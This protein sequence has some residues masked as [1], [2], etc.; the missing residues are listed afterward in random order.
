MNTPQKTWYLVEYSYFDMADSFWSM[1]DSL[2]THEYAMS[3]K[4][5]RP[6]KAIFDMSKR[7]NLLFFGK[8][9]ADSWETWRIQLKMGRIRF[10]KCGIHLEKMNKALLLMNPP[11]SNM[12]PAQFL[13]RIHYKNGGFS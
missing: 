2:K 4:W 3:V 9:V 7:G 12:N 8:K 13:W 1:A 6:K 10:W 5:I 11:Q